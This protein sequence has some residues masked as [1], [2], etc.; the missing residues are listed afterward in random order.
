MFGDRAV[1]VTSIKGAIGEFGAAGA[2]SLA[3]A[4]LCGARGQVAPVTGLRDARR[5]LSGRRQPVSAPLP[6]PVALVNSFA[7]GGTHVSVVVR[8]G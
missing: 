5:R 4:I 1:P 6:G 7:S 3:A 2:G 8:I